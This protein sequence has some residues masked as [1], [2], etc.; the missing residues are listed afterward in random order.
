LVVLCLEGLV[1]HLLSSSCEEVSSVEVQV[2]NSA[3]SEDRRKGSFNS[4]V[5]PVVAVALVEIR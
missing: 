4:S 1:V 5:V 2:V 3:D